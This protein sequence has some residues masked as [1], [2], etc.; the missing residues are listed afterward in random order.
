[1]LPRAG[2]EACA[3]ALLVTL[4]ISTASCRNRIERGEGEPATPGQDL[5]EAAAPA[6]KAD[7][8]VT[9]PGG[10]R[11]TL[12]P[13]RPG[14]DTLEAPRAQ[15]DLVDLL[16]V[17]STVVLDVR[18]ATSRNFTGKRLYPVARCLLRADAAER[19]ARVH[20]RLREAGYRLRIFDCYRPLSIQR[21][22]WA[23]VPDERYVAN[24][25]EGSR[26]NR[27]AAVDLTLADS[28]GAELPM[29]TEYDDFTHRAHRDWQGAT[30]EQL[31]NRR[32]L[33]EAMT[34]EG[35]EPLPTEWWHF[36][37]PDW[38]EHAILDVPLAAFEPRRS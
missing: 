37:A 2:R 5:G 11:D 36:D 15:P 1:M 24:P 35:F 16:D 27:A 34:G 33:E 3:T 13:E 32:R 8:R 12:G 25:A 31:A 38:K 10:G 6:P 30:P 17:D 28:T 14:P 9:A 20:A 23:L 18:Y 21:K 22:L 7:G 4:A 26:H 29:P 19:L